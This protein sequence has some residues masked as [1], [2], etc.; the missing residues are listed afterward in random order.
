MKIR[1]V[2][3]DDE[4]IA[5]EKLRS[6]VLKVPFLELAGEFQSAPDAVPLLSSG[7]V[8]ALFTDINMPDLDGLSFIASLPD[9]PMVV[10]T[11]AYAQYAVDSYR[12]S[13]VDYLLKP[14]GFADFQRAAGKLARQYNLLNRATPP[15]PAD[16]EQETDHFFVK[17]DS[18][19]RR[20]DF[21]DILYIKG[22]GE[23]LQIFLSGDDQPLVTLSSFAAIKRRLPAHFL[24]VHRSYMVNMHRAARV[25][26]L[27]IVMEDETYIPVS[28]SFKAPFLEYLHAR[29]VGLAG[30][31]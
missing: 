8:D 1:T 31:K 10:F 19:F 22:Y 16:T 29:S 5:L 15:G 2:I 9:P 18:R 7:T 27:R 28:D 4:P 12:L 23:Y 20:V 17:I 13:A 3:V 25:E 21:R 14:F 6:Y 11:T 30:N 26:R 24:Q